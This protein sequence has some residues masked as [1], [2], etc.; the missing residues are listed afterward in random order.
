ML[1]FIKETETAWDRLKNTNKPIVLYGMGNGADKILDW[2]DANGVKV[3]AVFAS[4]DF[5]RGQIFRGYK[6]CKYADVASQYQE[7][8]LVI[9]FASESP[10]V[11]E[12]FFALAGKHET[13]APHLPL[14]EGDEV[15]SF[16]W[17]AK[18][19]GELLEVYTKLADE[20]SREVFAATLNYKLSGKLS[21]LAAI[22]TMRQ[23]D[24]RQLFH[25]SKDETF[26]DLGAYDGD[27]IKE[28][29]NYTGS[30][31]RK[32]VALEPDGKNFKKLQRFVEETGLECVQLLNKGIWNEEGTL[33]FAASGG[34]QSSLQND[35]KVA[36]PVDSVDHIMQGQQVSYMKLD[37][38]GAEF[39][40]LSGAAETIGKW[41]PKLF[42]AAYH[43]DNDLWRLPLLLWQ[44]NKNYNIYL[45]KHPYVPAWELN[46][47][48][49]SQKDTQGQ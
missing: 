34:R 14:F 15:V 26:V 13:I 27:T 42:V 7:F 39:E 2:C 11:L 43:R 1:P 10:V 45:R 20:E 48:A 44:L 29:L 41:A 4:D 3:A 30:S 37:V 21:C 49:V 35:G 12:H 31:Y 6:I 25:F 19:K 40:A 9:A 32:I 8:L 33:S 47:L 23:E 46:F 18:Y 24:C 28:F 22:T 5:V 16:S 17:L 36:V 38:E